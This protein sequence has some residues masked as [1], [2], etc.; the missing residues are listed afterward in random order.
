MSYDFS[1]CK[2]CEAVNSNIS[3][4]DCEACSEC[5]S[6]EQGFRYLTLDHDHSTKS[7]EFYVDEDANLYNE[8]L[9][10]VKSLL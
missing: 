3:N 10:F 9:E 4:G 6:V 2:V 5:Y 1:V 8:S 7:Q